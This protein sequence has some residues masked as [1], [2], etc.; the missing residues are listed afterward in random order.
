MAVVAFV[1]V[2]WGAALTIVRAVA[3]LSC[4]LG[5]PGVDI[6]EPLPAA[7]RR[8]RAGG[9]AGVVIATRCCTERIPKG[10][11][12]VHLAGRGSLNKPANASILKTISVTRKV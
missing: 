12:H 11:A 1:A 7:D 10:L 9:R 2:E 4:P 3:A 6:E 5:R 8:G